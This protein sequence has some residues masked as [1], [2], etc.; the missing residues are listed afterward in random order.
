MMKAHSVQQWLTKQT[1]WGVEDNSTDVR[2]LRHLN[3]VYDRMAIVGEITVVSLLVGVL[4]TC[5]WLMTR[6]SFE[7]AIFWDATEHIC[8][9][10]SES[11]NIVYVN[12]Q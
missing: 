8:V 7:D 9:Y 12:N 11:G 1:T 4:C 2:T 5:A 3:A 10:D 6:T